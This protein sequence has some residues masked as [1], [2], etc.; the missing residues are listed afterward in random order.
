VAGGH[1][2]RFAYDGGHEVSRAWDAG[3]AFTPGSG[4]DQAT[5]D[6]TQPGD[7]RYTLDAVGR[8][9]TRSDAAGDWHLTWDHE[10]R[11]VAVV[12]P[13]GDHWHYRYD[14]FGRRIAKQRR[15]AK[16]AVLEEIGFVWSGDLLVEQNHRGRGGRVTTTAWEYHPAMAYPVAQVTESGVQAVMTDEAGV[17]VDVVGIDGAQVGNLETVPLRAG[18]RY[19]D[20]ETGLQYDRS[21]YYD[22]ATGGFLPQPRRAAAPVS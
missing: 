14:A 5:D 12:T 7:A 10:D 19:L 4:H 11:L 17:P 8:P 20:A 3:T 1:D 21:R 6:P 22:P 15:G 16:G 2:L 13:G 9:V 18:G